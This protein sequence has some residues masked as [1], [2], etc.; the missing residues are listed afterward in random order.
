MTVIVASPSWVPPARS[1][2][3]TLD[4]IARH[5]DRFRVV[6]LGAHRNVGE[7]RRAVPC[8]SRFPT[9]RLRDHDRRCAG[10]KASCARAGRD[11]RVI[12]GADALVEIAALPEVHSV[13]AAIVGA[14]G[15]RSTLAA[16]R[17][18]KRLLLAN[19]ES[20]VMAG[21][22]LMQMRARRGRHAA[23]HRQRT[24]RRIPVPAARCPQP[25]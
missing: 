16:A 1:A 20:L 17:A 13:M 10:S 6:A 24:Q 12:G 15:L 21:P 18:G 11:T 22:L 7:T 14:A 2:R 8:V 3:R 4:V 5:P 19:K 23:A 25:A 9:R